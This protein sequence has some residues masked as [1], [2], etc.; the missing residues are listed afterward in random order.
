MMDV[1]ACLGLLA[2]GSLMIALFEGLYE[3]W[4]RTK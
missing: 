2:N 4:E 3:L 1:I